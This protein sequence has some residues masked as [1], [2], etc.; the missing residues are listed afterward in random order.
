MMMQK[1]S[2]LSSSAIRLCP[3]GLPRSGALPSTLAHKPCTHVGVQA[4]DRDSPTCAF[5]GKGQRLHASRARSTTG[6]SSVASVTAPAVASED[7]S[8]LRGRFVIPAEEVKQLVA[9]QGGSVEEL[10]FSLI[11]PAALLARPPIS[12]YH[13]GAVGL[14][15]SGA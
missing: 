6:N 15:S 12:G 14:G 5:S 1:C 7:T 11:K 8:A 10:L 4:C 2:S 13:V 9:Q 3:S